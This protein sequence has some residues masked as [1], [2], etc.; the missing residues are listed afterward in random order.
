MTEPY[1]L[2]TD[3]YT[4][5]NLVS[6]VAN[7]ER[8]KS[9]MSSS[10]DDYDLRQPPV[11]VTLKKGDREWKLNVGKQSS[12][13]GG[14]V[15]VSSAAKP[16]EPMAVKKTG[17]DLVFK[18]VN[19]FRSKDLLSAD[20]NNTTAVQLD[21]K[22]KVVALEQTSEGRWRFQKPPHGP[23]NFEGST[24]PL[25]AAGEKKITGVRD[26]LTDARDLRVETD[27][28][29]LAEGVS[30][31]DL[32]GKYGLEKGKPETLRVE[33]KVTPG[34]GEARTEALLIG[35]TAP[36]PEEKK[37]DKKDT[38]KE[39]KKPADKGTEYYYARL[40]SENA[41]VR[42][43]A[44]KVK[45]LLDVVANSEPLRSHDLVNVGGTGK[46]HAVDVQAGGPTVKLRQVDG[47]WKLFYNGARATDANAVRDLID[48]ITGKNAVKTFGDK[49]DG[50]GF[51]KP[52]AVVSVWIDG[53][54]KEEPKKDEDKKEGEKKEE[55]PKDKEPS[56]KSDKPTVKLTFG[57]VESGP[58]IV[59]V[60]REAGPDR[61]VVTVSE[62]TLTKVKAEP[63]AYLD[64]KLPTFAKNVFDP[65]ENV[66]K[67]TVQ[68][69]GQTWELTRDPADKKWKGVQPPALAE[70]G[71]NEAGIGEVLHDLA[72]LR[73][74]KIIAEK[75]D[76]KTLEPLYGLG[77]PKVKVT[78]TV[79]KDDKTED[80]VYFF[81][82]AKEGTN[83]VFAR[84][85]QEDIIFLVPKITEEH[86]T[87]AELRDLTVLDFDP[88]KVKAAKITG[89]S[90]LN[91]PV[92][93]ELTRDKAN[94]WKATAPKDFTPDGVVV[95]RFIGNLAH[96]QGSRFVTK[97]A[98]EAGLDVNKGALKVEITV[99]GQP[100]LEVIVSKGDPATPDQ[101]Y[102]TSS[103]LKGDVVQVPQLLFRDAQ[104]SPQYFAKK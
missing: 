32:A 71:P 8:E 21:A 93:L 96:L 82:N 25:P 91:N 73:A 76:E 20:A 39:E 102:A 30:D 72:G 19:D 67:L 97:S 12:S 34:G 31:A 51:D 50:L 98:A 37:D 27:G 57:K 86:L 88:T 62:A 61:S 74:E 66:T 15:Y 90:V 54:K 5:N 29:F 70:R 94:E 17:L 38:S 28:D 99:E 68:R 41:V 59:Y 11:V 78:V 4:V 80:W 104:T 103:K 48:A 47:Q 77:S 18:K 36:K 10:L 24:E 44:P 69:G 35:K 33:V 45:P 60:L 6:Q 100:P 101:L 26:L 3:S 13:A 1:R 63:M 16:N 81:G 53:I 9:D 95:E 14:V 42:V 85:S 79:K 92:T 55:A 58:G 40:E 64:R 22:D 49:E 75:P 43:P 83:S 87:S 89:W 84:M 52:N 7:A 23:A 56:L 46:I 2:R 65:A